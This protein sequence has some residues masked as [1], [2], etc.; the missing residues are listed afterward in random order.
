M[1]YAEY[2]LIHLIYDIV[3]SH[4]LLVQLNGLVIWVLKDPENTLWHTI[5]DDR[6]PAIAMFVSCIEKILVTDPELRSPV[7]GHGQHIE[8]QAARPI[9]DRT[10]RHV[11]IFV[12]CA[13]VNAERFQCSNKGFKQWSW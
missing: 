5:F 10:G 8:I 3:G 11:L 6:L 7:L 12:F 1:C 13:V 4:E 9:A 2:V